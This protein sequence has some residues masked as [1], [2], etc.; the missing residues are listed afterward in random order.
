MPRGR[1]APGTSRITGAAE[2]SIIPTIITVHMTNSASQ[3]DTPHVRMAMVAIPH[4]G[5]HPRLGSHGVHHR[6]FAQQ[7]GPR[8]PDRGDESKTNPQPV[9]LD[10]SF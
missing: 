2:G 9:T 10:E 7:I 5:V 8:E 4:R 3:S 6:G 1:Y